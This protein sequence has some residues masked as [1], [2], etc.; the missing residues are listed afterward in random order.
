MDIDYYAECSKT[1]FPNP[2]PDDE[3]DVC[4]YDG[5]QELIA[6]FTDG[7]VVAVEIEEE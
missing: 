7:E 1:S 4:L 2:I 3:G 5:S 6:T